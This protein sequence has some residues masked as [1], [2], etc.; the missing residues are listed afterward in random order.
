MA[1]PSGSGSTINQRIALVGGDD[2]LAQLK[3]LGAT[4]QTAFEDLSNAIA[5]ANKVLAQTPAE[6]KATQ[7][8]LDR[9]TQAATN[10]G[11]AMG[12]VAVNLGQTLSAIGKVTAAITGAVG[13]QAAFNFLTTGSTTIAKAAS[14]QA[15]ALGLAVEEYSKLEF[16]LKQT[17]VSESE[18]KTA[19]T[20][21]NVEIQKTKEGATQGG[22][23]LDKLGISVNGFNG[24]T[25]SASEVISE[26][27]DKFTELPDGAQKSALAV[28][29][30]GRRSGP[31]LVALLNQGSE[32]IEKFK[33]RAASLGLDVTASEVATAKALSIAVTTAGEV[34]Q[35]TVDRIGQAFAPLI[36][37]GANAVTDFISKNEKAIV[38]FFQTIA[39][40]VTGLVDNVIVPAFNTISAVLDKIAEGINLVFGTNIS[41]QQIALVL[42]AAQAV[43][44]FTLLLSAVTALT[45]GF[46]LLF[47][48]FS[49][50]TGLSS[51]ISGFTVLGSTI[52]TI[53]GA[54]ATGPGLWIALAVAAGVAVGILL[55]LG[56]EFLATWGP[57]VWA[58]IS[59]AAADAATAITEAW[60]GLGDFFSSLAAS[61]TDTL[62][63]IWAAIQ[64][65][66]G[67][68]AAFIVDTYNQAVAAVISVFDALSTRVSSIFSSITAA[69]SSLIDQARQA[70]QAVSQAFSGAG[71]DGAQGFA[72]GGAVRGAGTGTSDSILAKVS[73]GEFIMQARAVRKWGVGFMRALNSGRLPQFKLGGLVDGLN[74][75]AIPSFADGGAVELASTAAGRTGTPVHLHFDSGD[76][77]EVVAPEDVASKLINFAT[78]QKTLRA[79]RSPRWRG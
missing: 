21:L 6:A 34:I 77:F 26:I 70:A 1:T 18:A 28:Q 69:L 14:E 57:Q 11:Q 60:N 27:A 73:N 78:T 48:I 7:T 79:G 5:A 68:A 52:T 51:V 41:G 23:A 12:N 4:G 8:A 58:A 31:E 22:T 45:G 56:Q 50:G 24:N 33:Q 16:A 39:D 65:A 61:V 25:K 20:A 38:G 74:S 29:L 36:T 3:A 44:V 30:F 40:T 71:G 75:L 53:L 46:K 2:I 17:G 47:A 64:K 32:G 13:L 37:R 49:A 15:Q 19:L 43:K 63:A 35:Q 59:Q 72:A 42:I 55:R 67:D 62:S 9:S 10:F 66:A 76:S 54:I